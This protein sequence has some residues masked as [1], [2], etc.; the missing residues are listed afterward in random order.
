MVLSTFC[1]IEKQCGGA[2][3]VQNDTMKKDSMV[4]PGPLQ[5]YF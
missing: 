5:Y 1:H 2:I 4:L 3:N